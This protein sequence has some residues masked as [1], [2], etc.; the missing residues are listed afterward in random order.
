[1]IR[2]DPDKR[3]IGLSLKRVASSE[4]L[5]MDW[6]EGYDQVESYDDASVDE[7][8]QDVEAVEGETD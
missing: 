5:D 2:I 4:Y 7:F 8:E 6:Q 1:M 3:R